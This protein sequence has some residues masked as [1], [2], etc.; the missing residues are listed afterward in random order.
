VQVAALR[1]DDGWQVS[2]Q[3]NGLGI[4]P[5]HFAKVFEPFRRLH[6]AAESPG[7]GMGLAISKRIVERLGGRIWV[8]SQ[9]GQGSTFLVMLPDGSQSHHEPSASSSSVGG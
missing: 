2:V 9:Y 4:L 3:D 5:E 6:R 8:E 7:S 1:V